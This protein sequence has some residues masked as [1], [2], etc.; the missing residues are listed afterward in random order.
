MPL[1]W[2]GRLY[3]TTIK[4][5]RLKHYGHDCDALDDARIMDLMAEH[6]LAGYGFY[7]ACLEL[8]GQ[9]IKTNNVTCELQYSVKTLSFKF[10][11]DI[12]LTQSY[13]STCLGLGLFWQDDRDGKVYCFKMLSRIEKNVA[14]NPQ[15]KQLLHDFER[16]DL[17]QYYVSTNLGLTKDLPSTKN[18]ENSSQ[19][20][21]QL[22]SKTNELKKESDKKDA[23]STSDT[24]N[25]SSGEAVLNKSISDKGNGNGH[26][27]HEYTLQELMKEYGVS[28]GRALF[29][30]Q[31]KMKHK[32]ANDW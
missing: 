7:F 24:I 14:Q 16:S 6:G 3:P 5:T 11:T 10:R 30:A 23:F 22:G 13:L 29:D 20:V 28:E 12:V 25:T 8:I 17:Y 9:K 27:P 21:N 26:K 32:K 31:E 4:G 2:E 15:F 1:S 18:V 19:L